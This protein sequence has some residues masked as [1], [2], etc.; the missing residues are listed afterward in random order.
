MFGCFEKGF[1]FCLQRQEEEAGR[2]TRRQQQELQSEV[3]RYAAAAAS[4]NDDDDNNNHI[5]ILNHYTNNQSYICLT[6]HLPESP[7]ISSNS[8]P[9]TRASC[10][11][12]PL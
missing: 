12:I 11:A 3:E 9:K 4:L 7:A 8:T 5:D 2:L 1:E 10:S 6:L